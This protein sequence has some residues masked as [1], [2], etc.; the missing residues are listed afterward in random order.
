METLGQLIDKQSILMIRRACARDTETKD[1]LDNLIKRYTG[2]I[3]Q[4]YWQVT[5]GQITEKDM[6]VQPKLKNYAHQ[7]N[8]VPEESRM[9]VAVQNLMEANIKL[10]ELE[11]ERRDT[12]KSDAER[13]KAADD[14]SVHNRLR[15]I[16]IDNIDNILWDQIQIPISLKWDCETMDDPGGCATSCCSLDQHCHGECKD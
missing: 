4:F 12:S 10:W 6:I 1:I 14:V 16:A 8:D 7:S 13:L 5:S 15:N 11:D 3:N 2:E 9:G